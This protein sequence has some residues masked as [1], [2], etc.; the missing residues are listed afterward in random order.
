MCMRKKL[1]NSVNELV[2]KVNDSNNN[3]KDFSL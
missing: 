1:I 2:R 3:N